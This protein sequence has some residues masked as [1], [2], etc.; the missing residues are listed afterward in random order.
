MGLVNP[1]NYSNVNLNKSAPFSADPVTLNPNNPASE[2]L[3]F[4]PV[5]ES[6]NECL[7]NTIIF[8]IKLQF[9]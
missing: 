8:I 7:D 1:F 9:F 5:A 6:M 2:K 3:K 4:N